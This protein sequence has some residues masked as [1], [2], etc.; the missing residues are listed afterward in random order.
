[1]N[2]DAD[3][4]ARLLARRGSR[5]TTGNRLADYAIVDMSQTRGGYV[6]RGFRCGGTCGA[7]VAGPIV[8]EGGDR[9]QAQLQARTPW[10]LYA[11]VFITIVRDTVRR[12]R[13]EVSVTPARGQKPGFLTPARF[14]KPLFFKGK[15]NRP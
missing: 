12:R 10:R 9:R 14:A 15:T 1:M 3:Q 4:L 11:K 2:R 5:S 7:F 13:A 6:V 8:V